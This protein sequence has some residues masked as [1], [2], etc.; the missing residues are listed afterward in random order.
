MKTSNEKLDSSERRLLF[1]PPSVK[2]GKE[3]E[4]R[5]EDFQSIATKPLGLGAFGEVFKV[6]HT[7]SGKEFAIKVIPKTRVLLRGMLQQVRRE[8][9]IMYC[10]NHPNIVKLYSHFE[11][12]TNFYLILELA[13]GGQLFTKLRKMK[14]FDEQSAAQYL[15]EVALAVQY[16]HSK[17]PPIIHRDIK[18]ENI[19]LDAEGNAKL[20]DFGWSNFFNEERSTYCGTLDYLAPEMIERKGHGINLDLWN[21]GVLLFEM[22]VGRAP[23]QSNTQ[24]EL[25]DKIRAAKIGFPKNFPLL[26]KDLVKRLLNPNPDLRITITKLLEHPWMKQHPPIRNTCEIETER[27]PLPTIPDQGDVEF[28]DECVVISEPL[29]NEKIK[30]NVLKTEIWTTDRELA[31]KQQM[32]RSLE[33]KVEHLRNR[34]NSLQNDLDKLRAEQIQSFTLLRTVETARKSKENIR[35]QCKYGLAMIKEHENDQ[36][37]I[38]KLKEKYQKQCQAAELKIKNSELNLRYLKSVKFVHEKSEMFEAIKNDMTELNNAVILFKRGL[39]SSIYLRHS[40]QLLQELRGR[41]ET[42]SKIQKMIDKL[43]ES[44]EKR[45]HSLRCLH[46]DLNDITN[47][48]DIRKLVL[49]LV[50]PN[51]ISN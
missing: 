27:T 33:E 14:S 3:R 36:K 31:K 45:V 9:R 2:Q 47:V 44:Y 12:N 18:P 25:F 41:A 43:R 42:K 32:L 16:L 8:V 34:N 7:A 37:K 23:F 17:D 35:K 15:R 28:T 5:V 29:R 24:A 22:L 20:G 40:S 26:A 39:K 48:L 10:L 30:A 38:I 51:S 50:A 49:N 6:K 11:D 21:L 1:L 19:L 13:E 46:S 4:C